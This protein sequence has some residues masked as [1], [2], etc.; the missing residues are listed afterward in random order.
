M[1]ESASV[2][3]FLSKGYFK[4][5]NCLREVKAFAA[6]KREDQGL[7]LV[8]ETAPIHGGVTLEHLRRECPADFAPEIFSHA[9][10]QRLI[11][12]HRQAR[13]K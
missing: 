5:L 6:A 8:H 4:S 9:N 1:A 3:L 2:L 7:I 10:L 11:P 12:F 13:G